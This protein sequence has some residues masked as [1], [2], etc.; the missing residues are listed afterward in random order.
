MLFIITSPP[1]SPTILQSGRGNLTRL[2]GHRPVRVRGVSPSGGQ[3][4]VEARRHP[5][6]EHACRVLCSRRSILW[7]DSNQ[8]GRREAWSLGGCCG[9]G[10][11]LQGVVVSYLDFCRHVFLSRWDP[12]VSCVW[13]QTRQLETWGCLIKVR[14]GLFL[15]T[16]VFMSLVTALEWV[17]QY[18]SYFGG[19]PNRCYN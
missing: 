2:A 4:P 12:L 1:L 8:D 17:H 18:I 13:I 15:Q 5:E 6:P 9:G 3:H 11:Q 14:V 7:R 10:D 16:F 19:D